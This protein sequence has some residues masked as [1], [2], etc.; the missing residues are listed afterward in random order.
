MNTR[1][2]PLRVNRDELKKIVEEFIE[3]QNYERAMNKIMSGD[4]IPKFIQNKNKLAQKRL[5]AH[6][7]SL[8]IMY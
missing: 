8:F 5:H 6:V 7:S 1:Y 4:W 3:S 2:K